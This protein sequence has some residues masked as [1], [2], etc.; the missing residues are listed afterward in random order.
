MVL[1]IITLI[2]VLAVLV[3]IIRLGITDPTIPTPPDEELLLQ[4]TVTKTADFDGAA[5]DLGEGFAPNMG[6]MPFQATID[7][8]TR[9][10]TTGDETYVFNLQESDASGSGFATIGTVTVT[11]LGVKIVKG[12]VSKRYVRLSIDVGGTTPS[13]TYKSYLSPITL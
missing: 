3:I 5:L 2:S 11:S 4:D 13:M 9:D 10:F 8:T 12:F 7:V 6:G 1:P